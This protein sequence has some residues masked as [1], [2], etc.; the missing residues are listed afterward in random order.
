MHEPE[1]FG[2]VILTLCAQA[3]VSRKRLATDA[4]LDAGYLS[5]LIHGE[6]HPARETVAALARVFKHLP[7]EL[8]LRLY[9]AAGY[10]GPGERADLGEF[11]ELVE[12][13]ADPRLTAHDLE[14]VR[15][16]ILLTCRNTLRWLDERQAAGP[17]GASTALTLAALERERIPL[18][19]V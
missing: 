2:S 17:T 6:R 9:H 11:A 15:L 14:L 4:H 19:M 18:G 16:D 1:T 10:A 12:L 8:E 5:R 13:L 7:P 3:G